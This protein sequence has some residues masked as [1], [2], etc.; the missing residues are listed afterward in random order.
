MTAP[1]A[2]HPLDIEADGQMNAL[3]QRTFLLLI[4]S[5]ALHS[6]EE[7]HYALWE[8]LAPARFL[9]GLVSNDLSLGFAVV[10]TAIVAFGIWTYLVP[11]RQNRS[12]APQ[13][14]WFWIILEFANGLGHVALAVSSQ[15]YFPGVYTAPLLLVFSSYLAMQ[16]MRGGH[17]PDGKHHH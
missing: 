3:S 11:V 7:H 1:P 8:V 12:Y 16:L 2:R 17:A 14:A 10:N 9:S 6:I 13:I 4:A 5:Q 15:A